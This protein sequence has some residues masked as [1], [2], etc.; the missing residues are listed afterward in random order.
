[1]ARKKWSD[2]ARKRQSKAIK[3]MWADKKKAKIK[4][5]SVTMK[6]ATKDT[7]EPWEIARDEREEARVKRVKF[8]KTLLTE[9]QLSSVLHAARVLHDFHMD[10]S[11]GYE[12]LDGTLPRRM[13]QAKED[14]AEAFNMVNPQGYKTPSYESEDA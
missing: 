7:R 6:M 13:L 10:Y 5:A 12:I 2:A 9:G 11:E 14:L 8:M 4:Q 3:K 1:M